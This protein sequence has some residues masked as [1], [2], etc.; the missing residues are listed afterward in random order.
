MFVMNMLNIHSITEDSIMD[1]MYPPTTQL[2]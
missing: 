2:Q 1:P